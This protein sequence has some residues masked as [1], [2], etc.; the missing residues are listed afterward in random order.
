M[1]KTKVAVIF[2]GR[3]GEH[4]VSLMSAAS[5][6][7]VLDP[8][9]YDVLGVGITMAGAWLVDDDPMRLLEDLSEG[10]TESVG[11]RAEVMTSLSSV[12][13]ALADADVIFPVLHGPYGEDGT[14]RDAAGALR[15]ERRAGVVGGDG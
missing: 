3:S 5:V 12:L 10:K 8:G 1:T 15:G 4:E 6:I 2:G 11:S 9:R 14:I 7:G 13:P